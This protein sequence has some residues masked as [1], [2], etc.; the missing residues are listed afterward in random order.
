VKREWDLIR[1]ILTRIEAEGDLSSRWFADRFPQWPAE[2][3]NYHLWLLIQAGL[4]TGHCNAD[5]PR[6]GFVCYGVTLTWAGHE[7]L[8][9]VRSDT[10]W[11]RIKARLAERSVD[12]SL[13]A[14]IAAARSALGG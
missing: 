13:D 3:V 9:A 4:I 2:A 5:A 14:I 7:F 8:A 10:A 12:L 1:L 11:S 6:A